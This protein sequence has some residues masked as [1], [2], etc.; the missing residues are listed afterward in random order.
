MMLIF[1][2]SIE[3]NTREAKGINTLEENL[4]WPEIGLKIWKI[5]WNLCENYSKFIDFD[6]Y[7]DF[8]NFLLKFVD[9]WMKITL[10]F[11]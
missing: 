5:K 3:R 1:V 9:Y 10:K 11:L 4:G 7:F 6:V 8:K 2:I